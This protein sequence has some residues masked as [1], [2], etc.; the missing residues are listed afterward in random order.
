MGLET[1]KRSRKPRADSILNREP[2]LDAATE[3]FA[4]GGPPARLEAVA[5]PA[6]VGIGALYRHFPTRE[7]LFEDNRCEWRSFGAAMR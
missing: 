6:E 2:L 5:R 7:A 3:L 4:A 1:A